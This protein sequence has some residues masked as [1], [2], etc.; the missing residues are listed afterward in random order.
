MT[1]DEISNCKFEPQVGTLLKNPKTEE[2]V[3]VPSNIFDRLSTHVK[4]S[5]RQRFKEGK[6]KKAI[7]LAKGGKYDDSFN[8][9]SENFDLLKVI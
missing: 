3:P 2:E 1:F 5:E 9:I 4:S 8:M 6:L 7:Q